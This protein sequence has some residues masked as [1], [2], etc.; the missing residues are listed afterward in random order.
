MHVFPFF[1][2]LA[3]FSAANF[4]NIDAGMVRKKTFFSTIMRTT[5]LNS[6]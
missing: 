6:N 1:R 4:Y 3:L 5:L 2:I